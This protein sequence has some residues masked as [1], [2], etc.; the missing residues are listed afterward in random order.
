MNVKTLLI[1]VTVVLTVII[2]HLGDD[3]NNYIA[4]I[5]NCQFIVKIV[6]LMWTKLW[7]KEKV[8]TK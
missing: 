3:F 7:K 2:N 6:W 8:F 1:N 5:N 4:K